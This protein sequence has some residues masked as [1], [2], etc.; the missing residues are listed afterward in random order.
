M[1]L[2]EPSSVPFNTLMAEIEKG[3]IKIPQFQRDFVWSKDRVAK[4]VDSIVKGYPIGTFILWKTKEELR[5]IRNL[6]GLGRCRRHRK[7]TSSSTFW[8]VSSV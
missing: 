3:L 7:V 4:L 2:P 8:M 1:Q 5:H 6:G